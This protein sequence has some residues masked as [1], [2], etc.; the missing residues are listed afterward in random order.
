MEVKHKV[1][2][3]NA[4]FVK[5]AYDMNMDK[6]ADFFRDVVCL[7]KS[8]CTFCVK[9]DYFSSVLNTSMR[10]PRDVVQEAATLLL[11]LKSLPIAEQEEANIVLEFV[12]RIQN[13][14]GFHTVHG[15]KR[16]TVLCCSDVA[17]NGVIELL[18]D[19]NSAA[20]KKDFTAEDRLEAIEAD[21]DVYN[22]KRMIMSCLVFIKPYLT[23]VEYARLNKFITEIEYK[24]ESQITTLATALEGRRKSVDREIARGRNTKE[25]DIY[26][27]YESQ[28]APIGALL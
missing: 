2:L 27:Y 22:M 24:S 19:I 23:P 1:I 12:R 6:D 16:Y 20:A 28:R 14:L 11:E 3:H 18:D 9:R 21:V 17:D 5:A 8:F 10:H 26:I 13:I 25:V 15:G 7:T 4:V